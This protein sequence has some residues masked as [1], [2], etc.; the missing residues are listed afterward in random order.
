MNGVSSTVTLLATPARWQDRLNANLGLYAQDA[1]NLKRVTITY[2]L[3]WEYLSEQVTGRPAQSGRFANIPAYSD[4][5]M[6]SWRTF[7]PRTAI[8]YD[9]FGSGKT[10]VRFG[11]NRFAAAATTTF[12]SLYDPGNA[13]VI[14][15]SAAW[16]DVNK[17][18]I[19]QGSPGCVYLT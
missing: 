8:V 16:T 6:P 7:S 3:R 4:I 17:D 5:H 9:L 15:T 12:A 2:G 1:W 18:D 10:A 19:A 13:I 11:F 14:Q